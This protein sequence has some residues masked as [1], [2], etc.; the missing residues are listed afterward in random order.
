MR[1]GGPPAMVR[2][3]GGFLLARVPSGGARRRNVRLLNGLPEGISAWMDGSDAGRAQ[4]ASGGMNGHLAERSPVA[5]V[6][7][8]A[9]ALPGLR[10]ARRGALIA[11]QA[12]AMRTG[13]E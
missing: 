8:D 1:R 6:L 5:D 10:D 12:L 4:V 3:T 2:A 13:L 7:T 9:A 11:A